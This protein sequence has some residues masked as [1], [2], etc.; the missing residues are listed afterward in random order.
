ML[1]N[2]ERN[3]FES[4]Q[5]V[6]SVHLK[7]QL[8]FITEIDKLK[9]IFRQTKLIGTQEYENDAE[10]SWHIALMATL[11]AEHANEKTLDLSKIVSMLLIH[12]IVEIDAGDTFAYDV[13]GNLDKLEREE[14]AASR[15]YG[16]L[17]CEEAVYWTSLWREFDEM[18]TPEAQYAASMDRLQ[19][20]LLNWMNG[21]GTWK[22]HGITRTQITKRNRHIEKGSRVLWEFAKHIIDDAVAKNWIID[23]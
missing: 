16:I 20:M 14:K 1:D 2:N 18:I 5:W 15:I 17:S 19:P 12:D 3:I 22:E 11:L 13:T 4:I 23:E 21:G 8:Q 7:K 6:Q 10:H 9:R